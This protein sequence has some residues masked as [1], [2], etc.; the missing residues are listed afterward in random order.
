MNDQSS[1]LQ[2]QHDVIKFELQ[3]LFFMLENKL[4]LMENIEASL[5]D[6]RRVMNCRDKILYLMKN[7]FDYDNSGMNNELEYAC[8]M[9]DKYQ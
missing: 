8:K 5:S 2:N 6:I 1:K 9:G 7:N 3:T 4:S